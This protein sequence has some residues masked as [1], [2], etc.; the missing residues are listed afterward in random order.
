M[1]PEVW[2]MVVLQM[3]DICSMKDPYLAYAMPGG[4]MQN[5]S[6]RLGCR[7]E[8]VSHNAQVLLSDAITT[9]AWGL[10]APCGGDCRL[11]QTS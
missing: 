2:W 11:G 6:S 8:D 1:C 4:R 9:G 3:A 5:M 10:T 7:N